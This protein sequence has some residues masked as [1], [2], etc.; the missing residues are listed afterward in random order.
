MNAPNLLDYMNKYF[1]PFLDKFV[2]V[3]INDI[4]IYSGTKKQ[5]EKHIKAVLEIL[6]EKQLYVKLSK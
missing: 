3:F 4:L 2:I 6:R 1:R 5:Q